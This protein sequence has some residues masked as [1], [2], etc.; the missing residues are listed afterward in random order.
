V[1]SVSPISTDG[2]GGVDM[3]RTT[4]LRI[5]ALTAAI[6]G[7]ITVATAAAQ[8]GGPTPPGAVTSPSPSGSPSANHPW[9]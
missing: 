1:D 7:L 2:N 9:D 3:G 8:A 5:V 4:A 6:T